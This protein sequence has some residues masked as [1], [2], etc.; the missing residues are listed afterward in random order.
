LVSKGIERYDRFDL[1]SLDL[2]I[3]DR[4]SI[5]KNSATEMKPIIR[6]AAEASFSNVNH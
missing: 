4:L 3:I 5:F 2:L 1:P 6:K